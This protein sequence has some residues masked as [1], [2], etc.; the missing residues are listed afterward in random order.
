MSATTDLERG[1]AVLNIKT[2]TTFYFCS[3]RKD[4]DPEDPTCI[5]ESRRNGKRFGPVRY[6][7]RSQIKL[8]N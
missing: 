3:Y 5:V 6:L 2:G 4:S 7:K 1:T 8:A